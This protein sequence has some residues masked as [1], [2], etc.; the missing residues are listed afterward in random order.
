[1][2]TWC[3]RNFLWYMKAILM[4]S[5]N[6]EGDWIPTNHLLPPN[7]SSNIKT[8]LYAFDP[9]IKGVA[10][11][12]PNNQGF[13]QDNKFF[14]TNWKQV[15][16]TEKNTCTTHCTWVFISVFQYLWY[17]KVLWCYQNRNVNNN[18][19]ISHFYLQCCLICKIC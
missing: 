1:M 8:Q 15:P 13:C 16:F 6:N 5:T 7:K 14:S 10:W 12:S 3:S 2:E 17:R 9:L 18:S 19:A 11:K 4:K